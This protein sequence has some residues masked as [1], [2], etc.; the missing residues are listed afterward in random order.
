MNETLL[1]V[2]DLTVTH[3]NMNNGQ[4]AV[5]HVSFDLRKGSIL[6]IVGES[7]AGKSSLALALMGLQDSGR[8]QVSGSI[9]F[10]DKDLLKLSEDE[11][12]RVRGDGLGM[13]FQDSA[14]ALDPSMRV[15]DQLA[16]AIRMHTDTSRQKAREQARS[17]LFEVGIS[18]DIIA[19]APYAY[20]LSGGLCQR[21][22][23]AMALACDPD[24]LIADEPTS[25]LD[26]TLQSQI[27][28]LLTARQ[29]ESGLAIVFISHDLAL[30]SLIADD[31]LVLHK[32]EMVERG[33]CSKVLATPVHPYTRSL[34]SAW[35]T[36]YPQGDSAVAPA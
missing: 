20:Q 11:Y 15:V 28:A 4:P 23:I 31:V 17:R 30:V 14:G 27:I 21:A 33:K 9:I 19:G 18:K 22:M 5:N 29:K 1:R 13:I 6:G 10:R 24:V 25:S 2:L 16:A 26:V 12:C 32:G 36:G 7:G 34:I 3:R 35:I 8:V